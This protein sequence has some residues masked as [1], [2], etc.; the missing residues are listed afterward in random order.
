MTLIEDTKKDQDLIEELG[1][2]LLI[3]INGK[4]ILFDT[5]ASENI[6][7]NSIALGIDISGIDKIIISHA[8]ADHGGG[9]DAVLQKN[10]SATVYMHRDS[11]KHFYGNIC[12][13][14]PVF[15]ANFVHPFIKK[16]KVFSK[17][18]GL[19]RELF[20]KYEDRIKFINET[21]EIDKNVFLITNIQN[22]YPLTIGNKFLLVEDEGK[23][24]FENFSHELALIVKENDKLIIFSGC[25]HNGIL[26]MVKT[27][28]DLF[29]EYAIKAIV[30]GLHLRFQPAKN[31]IAGS[32]KDIEHIANELKTMKIDQLYT[33]HCTGSKAY[34]ILK[35][36]LGNNISHIYTGRSMH[37]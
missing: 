25:C 7:K 27:V 1:L 14:L 22:K 33:G 6:I 20:T 29:P 26:N 28:K 13:I 12:A 23:L 31:N 15:L 37:I 16:S 36:V 34:D 10:K 5:G 2:S 35:N 8:H 3:E 17:Y 32:K 19:N 4:K 18:N 9:L 21:T 30:G 11:Q 24:N